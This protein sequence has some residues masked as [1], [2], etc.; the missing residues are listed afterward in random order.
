MAATVYRMALMTNTHTHLPDAEASRKAL[1]SPA[2]GQ[3]NAAS[4]SSI[5]LA[6]MAHFTDD[7]W[8]TPVANPD[9]FGS[10]GT[11]SPEGQAFVVEMHAAWRDW[12]AN[13]SPGANAASHGKGTPPSKIALSILSA[14]VG[15]LT[16]GWFGS[17]TA[18]TDE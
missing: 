12:V 1:S 11:Q 16:S 18:A 13:G 14:V 7:G 5:P 6:N 17:S 4:N 3:N 9:N 8:L 15:A 10:Q 2:S